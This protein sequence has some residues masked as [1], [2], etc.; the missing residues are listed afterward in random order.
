LDRLAQGP[1]HQGVVA[2]VRLPAELGE[3]DL[4]GREWPGSAL[5]LVLD[6]VTDPQNLGAAARGAEA[7]GASVLVSRRHRG[8]AVSAA[9]VRAS[10][11]ALLHLPMARV[12]N[13]GRAIQRLQEAGFWSIGLDADAPRRIDELD[14][15][16]GRLAVVAG[17][18]GPGL[19]RLVR[20]RCDELASIPMLGRVDSL[21]VAV[22]SALALYV[23][24]PMARKN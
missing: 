8:A 5:A 15:P 10:A 22:A 23:L 14:P 20:E 3:A 4:A 18:E 19:S 9:A 2:R 6:G 12:A 24:G 7:A 17:A 13:I 11:G 16:D 1:P 21:N